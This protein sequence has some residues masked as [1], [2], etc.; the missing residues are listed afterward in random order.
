MCKKQK[1][2]TDERASRPKRIVYSSVRL[3]S[4]SVIIEKRP[5]MVVLDVPGGVS[6]AAEEA[7][8]KRERIL[9]KRALGTIARR[10]VEK[11]DLVYPDVDLDSSSSE[12]V[13]EE[14]GESLGGH[15]EVQRNV[16]ATP[17]PPRD[18][19]REFFGIWR[20]EEEPEEKRRKDFVEG[21]PVASFFL[22]NQEVPVI[23]AIG[24]PMLQKEE[25]H[26]N[27]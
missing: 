18:R 23:K 11:E 22:P 12:N 13:L 24:Q 10:L 6:S 27:K 3:N 8:R 21:R 14:I 5:R 25:Y 20:K 17:R 1:N 15:Q 9:C 7:K 4:V 16:R 26:N 2:K 19:R